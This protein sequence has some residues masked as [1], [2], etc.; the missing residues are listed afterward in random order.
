MALWQGAIEYMD[1]NTGKFMVEATIKPTQN[2]RKAYNITDD[3]LNK[4]QQITIKIAKDDIIHLSEFNPYNHIIV[5]IR[6]FKN[7]DTPLS[8]RG[9]NQEIKLDAYQKRIWTLEGNLIKLGE[10][11]D[12]AKNNPAEFAARNLDVIEKLINA[13]SGFSRKNNIEE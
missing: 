5:Y 10:D 1:E 7:E 8:L 9:K 12:V 4:N 6:T 11:L 13:T 3:M 2:L